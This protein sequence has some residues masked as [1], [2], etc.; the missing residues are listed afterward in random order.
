MGNPEVS[1]III[2]Y[3]TFKLTADCVRSVIKETKEAIYEII[4]VDNASPDDS[5][6]ELVRLFPQIFLVR[7]RINLGFAK[8]NNLGIAHARGEFILLL[9]SDTILVND[10][11]SV[12]LKKLRAEPSLA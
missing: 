5:A 8:G 3:N 6:D 12:A 7:S 4:L 1:V 11:I 2:N 9:N 10:A